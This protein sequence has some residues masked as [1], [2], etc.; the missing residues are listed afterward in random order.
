MP[1]DTP[2]VWH[3]STACIRV[4]GAWVVD[5]V[6]VLDPYV[7]ALE[8]SLASQAASAKNDLEPYQL[9]LSQIERMDTS[10]AWLLHRLCLSIRARGGVVDVVGLD[11][12]QSILFASVVDKV[13]SMPRTKE[14]LSLFQAYAPMRLLAHLGERTTRFAR[15]LLELTGFFGAVMAAV[16][17][18]LLNPR[19]LRFVSIVTHLERAGIHSL[20]I[21]C[22]ISFLIGAIITQQGAFQLRR[23]GAEVFVVNLLGV[24]VLRELG[25]LLAAIMFA[26]RSGSAYTAEIGSMKMR[27]EID[28][29]RVMGLDSIEVLVLPRMIALVLAL[30]L[31]TVLG[32]LSALAGGILT[33]WLYVGIEPWA[34]VTQFRGSVEAYHVLVGLIKAPFMALIIGLVACVEGMR[35]HGSTDSLGQHTT[36]SVV[37]AIFM[38]IVVDGIFAMFF[39][40][41]GW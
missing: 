12:N 23:F 27:E 30:P 3:P 10:G 31:V 33:A 15:D 39:A 24:L 21:V 29:M 14:K 38:V 28:A 4:R 2:L 6:G 1:D 40:S 37:K 25:S 7:T 8:G 9:D 41:I 36:A 13:P 19:R 18:S 22:L 34:F 26:G 5:H 16:G 32:N 35:V 11:A 17:R 20:P